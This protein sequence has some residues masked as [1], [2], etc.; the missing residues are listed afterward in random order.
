MIYITGDTHGDNDYDKLYKLRDFN[1]TRDD[2]LII[3]GDAGICWI[4]ELTDYYISL[5]ER[6]GITIIY[7]DGNH[8]NFD[9]L[10]TFP[11]VEYHGALMHKISDHIYHVMRG[12]IMEI[13]GYSMLCIGGAHS[14]D[15]YLRKEHYSWWPQEDISQHDIDNAR[16]NLKKY[17]N[18]VD[19]VLTHCVD[20]KTV[21]KYFHLSSDQNTDA[22]SFIDEEVNYK[23]WFFG[24]YHFD[25]PV[26][27]VKYCFYN[28]IVCLN[29]I[30]KK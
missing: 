26:G 16:C 18:F 12:E 30:L 19:L 21:E 2:T 25:V 1:I 29:N 20:S 28:K 17:D 5:Y 22:L 15:K 3:L 10:E 11:I 4:G 23:Y 9:K 6:I 14:T 24:H 13:E 8:E 7:V 27:Q